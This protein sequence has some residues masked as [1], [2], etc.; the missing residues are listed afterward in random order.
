MITAG[1]VAA[2]SAARPAVARPA[3]SA[4]TAIATATRGLRT[5][6]AF[7]LVVVRLVLILGGLAA[8]VA[9]AWAIALPAGLATLGLACLVLE[10]LVKGDLRAHR[11]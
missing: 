7:A 2:M 11:P 1:Y 9:A 10:T 3:E 5:A 8:F 4:R 6:A